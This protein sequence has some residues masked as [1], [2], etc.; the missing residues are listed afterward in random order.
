MLR[1]AMAELHSY[2]KNTER[3]M[4]QLLAAYLF[5]L[6]SFIHHSSSVVYNKLD[7]SKFILGT[8]TVPSFPFQ[9]HAHLMSSNH[10]HNNTHPPIYI[11]G[12]PCDFLQH[13]THRYL[14][15]VQDRDCQHRAGAGGKEAWK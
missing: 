15:T 4:R 7:S 2:R 1:D 13:G 5:I 14:R 3:P 8:P 11:P 9:Y 12:P 6:D 10:P